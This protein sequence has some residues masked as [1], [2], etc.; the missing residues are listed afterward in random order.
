MTEM[1]F[2]YMLVGFG[3]GG[4]VTLAGVRAGWIS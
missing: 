1:E 4:L 2:A 3:I